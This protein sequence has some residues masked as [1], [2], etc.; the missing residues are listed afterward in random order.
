MNLFS[1]TSYENRESM[2]SKFLSKSQKEIELPSWKKQATLEELLTCTCDK[3]ASV[4]K[5]A[6]QAVNEIHLEAKEMAENEINS[7]LEYKKTVDELRWFSSAEEFV[8]LRDDISLRTIHA[9][10][11]CVKN[12]YDFSRD[13]YKFK[14][15]LFWVKSFSYSEK[16]LKYGSLDK[17]YSFDEA[18]NLCQKTL[19]K[20]DWELLDIFNKSLEDWKLDVF[21]HKW[22]YWWWF[23]TDS[24][25]WLPVYILINY[26]KKLEDVSTLIH[27]SGHYACCRLQKKKLNAL[28]FWAPLWFAE[29]PSTFYE[30]LL[31]DSL[32]ATLTDEELLVFHVQNLD[33]IVAAVQRQVAEYRF[34]QDLHKLFREKGYL[35]ADEIGELFILHMKD[36][37]WEWIHY[38]EYDNNRWISRDHNRKFF[39]VYSYASGYLISQAMI[40][41]LKEWSLTINQVKSF[42]AA[43]DS[44]SA[45]EIF[46][47][48]WIDITK[49]E[50]REE[51]L[52]SLKDYLNETKQLAKKLGKI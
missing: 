3:D 16:T 29:T 4:R 31:Q 32:Q 2:T 35:S 8:A 24:A 38:D 43:W 9:M 6:I 48:M 14:A 26:T 20:W 41:K 50:F 21:P 23:C 51:S 15:A 17:E 40:R 11:D 37:T 39:Y 45:E 1:K 44:K 19:W 5:Q 42:F 34:E 47:D 36:Y 18:I 13:F 33:Y 49:K 27:E 22:K 25:K 7:I 12:S 46:M 52:A 30:S 28:E 10:I